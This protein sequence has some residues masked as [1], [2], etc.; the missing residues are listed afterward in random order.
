MARGEDGDGVG[1]NQ[2]NEDPSRVENLDSALLKRMAED[3]L[4]GLG[5]GKYDG[6]LVKGLADRV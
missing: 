4:A 3:F 1:H 5:D 6:S 2:R